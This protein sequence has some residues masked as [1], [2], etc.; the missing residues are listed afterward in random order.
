MQFVIL[1]KDCKIPGPK[2]F[3]KF[4]VLKLTLFFIYKDLVICFARWIH[5]HFLVLQIINQHLH[6]GEFNDS[7][8]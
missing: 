5:H 3:T 4:T 2:D 1:K 7:I 6:N 8:A